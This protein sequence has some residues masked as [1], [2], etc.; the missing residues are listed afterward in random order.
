MR[1]RAQFK[2]PNQPE[3]APTSQPAP[4][5]TTSTQK[6]F[7]MK[8][9]WWIGITL[10]AMFFLV[11]FM[12]S[13]FNIVSNVNINPDGTSLTDRYYLSGPDPYYNLRLVDQTMQ[14]G[15]F[16]YYS[17]TNLDPLLAYPYGQSGGR[18]PL[19]VMSAI[20]FSHL[21]TPFMSESDALGYSMQFVPALFGALLVFPVYFIGKT[22]FNKKAGLI[23]A[24]LIGLIP[25]HISSGHGSAYAL[26]DHDSFNLLL[27][28]LTFLFL[29]KSIKEKDT[30]RR[31]L[32]AILA[33]LPLAALSMVWV[34]AQ[35]LYTVITVY[36]VVQLIFDLFTNKVEE[37]FVLSTSLV[38]FT[39]FIVSW[40]FPFSRGFVLDLPFYLALG[41]AVF[42]GLCV[43]FK[44]KQI[45]WVLSFPMIAGV[46][47]AAAGFLYIV[48]TFPQSF[49]FF[50]PLNDLSRILYGTGIYG[51]KVSLTIAEAGT[52]NLSRTVMSYGPAIY[53]LA[54]A[55][56]VFLIYQY[57]KQKGRKDYLM[58]LSLFV[59]NIWLTSTAGRFLNDMVP[60]IAL[61]AGW[62][63][64]YLISKID[65]KQMVRNIR[66]AGGGFRGI[67]KGV[68]IY[69]L[70]GVLFVAFLILI[71]NGF[72]AL[73]A[74]VPSAATK[75]NTSNM[76][77]DFFGKNHSSAFGSSAYKEQY[78]VDAFSWLAKQ[79]TEI[80]E[81]AKRPAFISWW[82]YGFYEVAVGGH[83]TVADNFQD[84]IPP[85]AN[86]HTAT[87]EKEGIAV[88]I[89]RLLEGNLKDNNR[90]AFSDSVIAALQKHL[91]NN[92]TT[93]ITSWMLNPALS[94]SQ[95][96]PIGVQYDLA[97]SK[98][99]QVGEQYTDNAYYHDITQ[100]LNSSL[101]DEQI[102]WLYHDIQQTTGYSIR[103]YGVEGYDEQIF[104][105]FAFLSDKSNILT[106]L[107]TVGT[108][109]YNPEDDFLQIVYTGYTVN[110]DGSQGA[111]GQ[112]TA[113]ELNEMP[114]E[115]RNRVAITGTST[116]YKEAYFN[117]MF[118]K[119]YIGTPAQQDSN[120]NYQTPN[121]QIP[122]YA[123]KHFVPVYISPFPYYS[124]GRSAVVIAKYYEGA[125]FNGTISC[126]N[127]PLSFA[128]AAIVDEY[129]FPHDYVS[130]DENGTFS[131]LAPGGNIT[132][133]FTYANE[134]FLK[135]ITLNSTTD[136]LYAPVTDAEAMRLN[137]TKYT[138]S[139][140]ITVNLSTLEGYVYQ[141]NNNNNT[142][143]SSIDTPLSGINVQL[144]DYYFGR[145]VPS[146][147]TDAQGHYLFQN[148]YPSKYNLSAVEG[149]YT[150]LN[151]QA[152]NIEPGNNSYNISKPKLAGIKGIIYQDTNNDKK[153]TTG[154]EQSDAQVKLLYTKLNGAKLTIA[155]ITTGSSGSYE[156]PSLVP[157]AYT[158]NATKKNASTGQLDFLT[159]QAVSLTANKTSWVNVSLTYAPVAVSGKTLYNGTGI[160]SIPITFAPDKSVANNTATKQSS[161]TTTTQGSYTASLIPGTYNVTVKKTES[162]TTVY[163]F[164]GK[165]VLS[166]GQGT[167]SYNITLTKTSVTVTGATTYNGTGKANMTII[168]TKDLTI[169]NNTAITTNVKTKSNGLYTIE[170]TPGSYNVTVETTVNESGQNITYLST[171]RLSVNSG[172][173]P[174]VYNIIL[175]REQ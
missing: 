133:L 166:I 64:W 119:A 8:K 136:V 21:L 5:T 76:K 68:R 125:F 38:L 66:N 22:L 159:E 33:G 135:S 31:I 121:Q 123:M 173:A 11:L 152:I 170:L 59:I 71:P 100:L 167:A 104:N 172:E 140:S 157:G 127:T 171:G 40:P 14:T 12:N 139:F 65:Y 86:F 30:T 1:K 32:Y 150:L 35:F 50:T 81:P 95:G 88:W 101:T 131:L 37:G 155:N 39:G 149:D 23:A 134:V 102:T 142:Y 85:A 17:A 107:R 164:T 16:P 83:P 117:T 55:G 51:N 19:L 9:N 99:I 114:Q 29:I 115:Q 48:Y 162:G 97:L 78:W 10:I 112:W 156:F 58:I 75:N 20:G 54:W 145:S 132:L 45:P 146:V 25:I 175:T 42:G 80:T 163:T 43:L 73:D 49:S 77:Y 67:R 57:V 28:F 60:L 7:R 4:V 153:Y 111:E 92:N 36:V 174:R 122:C 124:Q 137:G 98:L 108:E 105:I 129:G 130:T 24:L 96:K 18:G 120:G 151:M 13:Y 34:E 91:G 106:A 61:L 116:V 118:Y 93:K 79:D 63:I 154:E 41:V 110:T 70:L 109:F 144:N 128:T 84:G 141:D 53:W 62:I 94:P 52:Y 147:T 26:F 87:S 138:R 158:I 103:Y 143:D 72:L 2:M 82:D 169:Q 160:T 168:F 90:V 113:K 74:A 126:N 15:R 47:V 44:R 69:H 165:L 56:F 148:L 89:V 27:Y 46:G 161:A 6:R 3:S